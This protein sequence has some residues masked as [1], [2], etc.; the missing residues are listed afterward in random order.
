MHLEL[1]VIKKVIERICTLIPVQQKRYPLPVLLAPP[2]AYPRFCSI[3][4][5]TRSITPTGWIA[6]RRRATFPVIIVTHLYSWVERSK[7]KVSC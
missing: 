7:G 4:K 1:G 3:S 5:V 2:P 6:D